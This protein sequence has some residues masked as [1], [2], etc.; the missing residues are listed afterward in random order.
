M[1][2]DKPFIEYRIGF[3]NQEIL[4]NPKGLRFSD[5][6]PRYIDIPGEP[7]GVPV[8]ARQTIGGV[9]PVT[10]RTVKLI[11][12]DY[13]PQRNRLALAVRRESKGGGKWFAKA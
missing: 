6:N 3:G 5:L 10:D 2:S 13:V 9:T 4:E 7:I 11:A 8:D 12:F 1:K